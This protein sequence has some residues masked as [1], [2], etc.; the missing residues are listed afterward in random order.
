MAGCERIRKLLSQLTEAQV[1]VEN[2][3]DS[4]DVNFT[5]KRDELS[6]ICAAPLQQLRSMLSATVAKTG[7][8]VGDS[9]V[10]VEI[11]GGGMR[12]Q[13]SQ[14]IVHEVFGEVFVFSMMSY[15]YRLGQFS[16]NHKEHYFRR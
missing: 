4:G 10:C 15:F 13:V 8:S 7:I 5:L 3:T 12:M 14:Q 2:L 9:S 11:L 16:N 6:D 1:T